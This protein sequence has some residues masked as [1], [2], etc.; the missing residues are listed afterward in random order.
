MVSLFKDE[1][2]HLSNI[3]NN[4][5][6]VYLDKVTRTKRRYKI[7]CNNYASF[8]KNIETNNKTNKEQIG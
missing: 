8:L 7:K 6:R 4:S 3:A 1:V 5:F 2:P